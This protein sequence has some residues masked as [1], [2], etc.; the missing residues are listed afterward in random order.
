MD[1]ISLPCLILRGLTS[2]MGKAGHSD[3]AVPI[4]PTRWPLAQGCSSL[5]AASSIGTCTRADAQ[6]RDD[7]DIGPNRL[8]AIGLAL[9][10]FG[11]R[12][13]FLGLDGV[14]RAPDAIPAQRWVPQ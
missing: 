7:L 2:E 4:Q 8:G 5:R 6:A 1:G 9:E 14:R 10:R 13:G 11:Y 12:K 3:T